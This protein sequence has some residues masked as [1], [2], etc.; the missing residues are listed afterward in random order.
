MSPGDLVSPMMTCAGRPG[1]IRC[2]L[3]VVRKVRPHLGTVNI[4]CN[5]G[6]TVWVPEDTLEVISESR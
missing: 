6:K 2:K 1:D 3:S 4:A 5:C